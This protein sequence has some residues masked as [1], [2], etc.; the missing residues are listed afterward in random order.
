MGVWFIYCI[1]F[2]FIENVWI[3]WNLRNLINFVKVVD[4]L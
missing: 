2:G 3:L 1:D 4:W